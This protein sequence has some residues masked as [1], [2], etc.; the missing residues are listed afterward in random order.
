VGECGWG[1][2]EEDVGWVGEEMGSSC[3]GGGGG[4]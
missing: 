4:V 1:A 2:E 3:C